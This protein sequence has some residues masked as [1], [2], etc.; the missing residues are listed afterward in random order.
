MDLLHLTATAN[1]KAA[2]E[3]QIDGRRYLVVPVVMLVEGVHHGSAGPQYYSPELLERS[4]PTWNGTPV[5]VT[6]KGDDHPQGDDEDAFT[7]NTPEMAAKVAVGQVYHSRYDPVLPL[8]DGG[9]VPAMVADMYV[10]IVKAERAHRGIVSLLRADPPVE[11][12]TGMRF[13]HDGTPG[14]W[15]GTEYESSIVNMFDDHLALLPRAEGACSVAK[16][17]GAGMVL[18]AEEVRNM[19]PKNLLAKAKEIVGRAIDTAA[20]EMSHDELAEKIRQAVYAMDNEDYSYYVRDVYDENVVYIVVQRGSKETKT[21]RRGY[22]IDENQEVTLAETAE[23]VVEKR[24]YVPVAGDSEGSAGNKGNRQKEVAD[25]ADRKE[26]IERLAACDDCT[27]P[28]EVLEKTDDAVLTQL[29]ANAD[30]RDEQA[31]AERKRKEDAQ[32]DKGKQ[33]D[34]PEDG[35]NK[36]TPADN[37]TD[38]KPRVTRED[39]LNSMDPDE[40]A[41][42]EETARMRKE[43]R[44]NLIKSIV[45]NEKCDWT[46]EDLKD[47]K[48][49]PITELRKLAKAANTVTLN[50]VGG[51]GGGHTDTAATSLDK[52]RA[53]AAFLRKAKTGNDS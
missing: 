41:D 19:N 50:M 24:E 14:E 42:F 18:N 35:K 25:M 3:E 21:M 15:K 4:A 10:D 8:P 1:N 20:N 31:E 48:R 11:V 23:Q 49:W 36:Q 22:E 28:T 32:A 17:C 12:S 29:V 13:Q 2:R 34:N 45:E 43:T 39:L 53:P 52:Q 6:P 44:N 38:D 9:T 27:I 26:M 40:R 47:P 5:V 33:N 7:V 51:Q 46:E 30:F 37:K 16:G